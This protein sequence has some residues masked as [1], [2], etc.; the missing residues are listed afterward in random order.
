MIDGAFMAR[1]KPG[2]VLVNTARGTIV[3]QVAL[4]ASLRAGHLS[5]AGI[6][7]FEEE[8]VETP[9]SLLS[10]P[11]LIM[12]PHVAASTAEGLRRMAL[13]SAA[14]ALACFAGTL[15]PDVIVNPEVLARRN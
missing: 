13:D 10:T 7:V 9:I 11:N 4:E 14:A 3:D 2:A 5:A 12:T 6:D 8:P 15:D 1:M